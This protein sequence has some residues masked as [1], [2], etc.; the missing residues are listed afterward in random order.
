M[1]KKDRLAGGK[2]GL[3][4]NESKDLVRRQLAWGEM[5]K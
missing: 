1:E 5:A 3:E 4:R 2:D